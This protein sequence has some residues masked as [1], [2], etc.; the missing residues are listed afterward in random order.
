MCVGCV[1]VVCQKPRA[2]Y[3]SGTQHT[4]HTHSTHP[5]PIHTHSHTHTSSHTCLL[6]L[7]SRI[8]VY[9][10]F[11]AYPKGADVNF[12]A[13]A[14]SVAVVVFVDGA[15]QPPQKALEHFYFLTHKVQ[16][17]APSDRTKASVAPSAPASA[18]LLSLCL[19]SSLSPLL[20][21]SPSPLSLSVSVLLFGLRQRQFRQFAL[22]EAALIWLKLYLANRK[23]L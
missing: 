19:T 7:A 18:E 23:L 1:C 11:V 16:W 13:A 8:Q 9:K 5:L 2:A 12:A 15:L 20:P 21:P 10:K 3:A 6:A 17:V 4:K 14:V 22:I